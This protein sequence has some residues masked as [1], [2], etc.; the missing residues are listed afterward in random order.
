LELGVEKKYKL[1][2]IFKFDS[3]RKRMS[4][5]VEE[6]DTKKVL[7]LCKGADDVIFERSTKELPGTE[8]F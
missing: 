1:L 6:I 8:Q 3:N 7:L 5:V 4:V 2:Y